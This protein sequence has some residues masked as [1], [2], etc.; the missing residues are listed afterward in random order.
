MDA[1]L[2]IVRLASAAVCIQAGVADAADWEC[3]RAPYNT[4]VNHALFVQGC[5]YGDGA[6]CP[7]ECEAGYDATTPWTETDKNGIERKNSY[8]CHCENAAQCG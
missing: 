2:A 1:R 7:L 6:W 4:G 3:P 5:S 8:F